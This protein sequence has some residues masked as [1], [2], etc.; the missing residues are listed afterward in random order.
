MERSFSLILMIDI[1][2]DYEN[3]GH[4]NKTKT[5]TGRF[6]PVIKNAGINQYSR[7]TDGEQGK[8]RED[9]PVKGVKTC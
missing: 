2:Q 3:H 5:H 1:R 8:M 7:S 4:N 9:I 6:R